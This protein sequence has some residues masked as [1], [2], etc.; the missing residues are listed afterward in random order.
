MNGRTGE[1]IKMVTIEKIN[2]LYVL[3]RKKYLILDNKGQYYTNI[4]NLEDK[5]L[6]RL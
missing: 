2:E 4:Y 1:A 5:K 3:V 6:N